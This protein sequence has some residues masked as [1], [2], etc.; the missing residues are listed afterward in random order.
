M[1]DKIR[2]RTPARPLA[3]MLVALNLFIAACAGAPGSVSN[4]TAGA[5]SPASVPSPASAASPVQPAPSAQ[6]AP[7]AQAATAQGSP[8]KIGVLAD[9]TG[10]AAFAGAQ[11][12]LN[13]DLRIDEINQ[14]GGI[15]GRPLQAIY[16]DP[17]SDP[18]R[19][20]ELVIQLVQ[21]DNVDALMGGVLTP[22]CAGVAGLAA[23]L[24]VV[25]LTAEGC[26]GDQVTGQNCTRYVFRLYPAGVQTTLPLA[27]YMVQTYG[28]NWG[29]VYT[30]YAAG[31]SS[32]DNATGRLPLPDRPVAVFVPRTSSPMTSLDRADLHHQ[33][34]PPPP[35]C[36]PRPLEWRLVL[37]SRRAGFSRGTR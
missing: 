35:D 21:Q 4:P 1:N 34:D 33:I 14:A 17:G 18:A 23:Q 26:A 9:T 11:E 31:Q 5:V 25:Y 30:D 37:R 13:A 12:R 16:V 6:V 36:R 28:P 8:I 10:Q 2:A 15:N 32:V 7:A 19:A 29:I 20:Q 22:E 3:L 24:Q 27:Q